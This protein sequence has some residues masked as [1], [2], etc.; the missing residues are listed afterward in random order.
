MRQPWADGP[1][2]QQCDGARIQSSHRR[3]GGAGRLQAVNP[4]RAERLAE[5]ASVVCFLVP[6]P[7]D[8]AHDVGCHRRGR[9]P[10]FRTPSRGFRRKRMTACPVAEMNTG[11]RDASG[12]V[13]RM[14]RSAI[15]GRLSAQSL[16]QP[17]DYASLHPG[18][19]RGYRMTIQNTPAANPVD[20]ACACRE[21]L[22]RTRRRFACHEKLC[23]VP[24]NGS[25]GPE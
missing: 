15:R 23:A 1:R 24:L 7:C 21:P 18:Y 4:A 6:A 5:T 20:T 11:R 8:Q 16:T 25:N 14:K 19:R 17:P 3:R 10:A 12:P 2:T 13:A 9:S 22:L